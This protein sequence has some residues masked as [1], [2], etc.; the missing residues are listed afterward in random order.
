M[1]VE[2]QKGCFHHLRYTRMLVTLDIYK[3]TSEGNQQDYVK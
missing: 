3:N 1:T 2:S